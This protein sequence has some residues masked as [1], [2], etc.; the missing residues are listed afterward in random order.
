MCV[1]NISSIIFDAKCR[2]SLCAVR[3]RIGCADNLCVAAMHCSSAK[4]IEYALM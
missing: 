4:F 3:L 2:N 1:M